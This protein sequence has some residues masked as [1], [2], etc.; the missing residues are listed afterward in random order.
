MGTKP[1]PFPK[2]VDRADLLQV[3]LTLN[4]I[5]PDDAQLTAAPRK[6]GGPVSWDKRIERARPRDSNCFDGLSFVTDRQLKAALEEWLGD[7]VKAPE[8]IGR[9]K[10]LS[11]ALM[12]NLISEE[13]AAAPA[14]TMLDTST[15]RKM[16]SAYIKANNLINGGDNT[17]RKSTAMSR[18]ELL[19]ALLEAGLLSEAQAEAKQVR[20]DRSAALTDRY[21]SAQACR[22]TSVAKLLK[23]LPN[24]SAVQNA[25]IELSN[26]ASLL[27]Y[28]R[29]FL[30]WLHLARL[31]EEGAPLPNM[32]GDQLNRFVRQAYTIRTENSGVKNPELD[33]TFEMHKLLFP[34]LPR[35]NQ[36]N[37]VT[38][39]ANAYAGAMRRHFANAD[40]VKQRIK[41]FASARLFG[42]ASMPPP[43]GEEDADDSE[44]NAVG[45]R[46]DVGSSPLYNVVS[47]LECKGFVEEAMHP[48]Q[49]EVLNEIR[50]ILG[51]PRGTELD[52]NWLRA[53]IH[54]SIR[55]SLATVQVLD[56]LRD[57]ADSLQKELERRFPDKS[58]RPKL[59]KGS[60]RGL[61]FA[62]LNALKRRFVTVDATDMAPLLG[63][64][65]EGPLIAHAVREMLLPNV[66]AIYGEKMA[67]HPDEA[68]ARGEAWYLTGTFDTDGYSI[69]PHFQRRKTP[70]EAVDKSVSPSSKQSLPEKVLSPPRL[71]LLVD[72]GRVN[73]VTITVM[74]DGKVVMRT[75]KRRTRPLKFTLTARQYYSLTGQTRSRLIR[76]R[77]Q[78]KDVQGAGL[79]K[80]QSATSLRTGSCHK[81]VEYIK[82]SMDHAAASDQGAEERRCL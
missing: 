42:L 40:T 15:L 53:N 34:I 31:V 44:A 16:W 36:I 76:E 48:R 37:V 1:T 19:D 21:L 63:L 51:L 60:A 72:P 4:L 22:R 78:R 28:Q 79:R 27:F 32:E 39:A 43:K 14:P 62:P 3:A 5:S 57:Q 59:K 74:L 71:L 30:I 73:I 49:V 58:T 69:H 8:T 24:A 67:H 38:H 10:L 70:K 13:Q 68:T 75:H 41:R 61:H 26:Q 82:A 23:G 65:D 9:Q 64:P 52:S 6:K 18:K 29:S 12:M 25:L 55:F 54:Q 77:R 80:A 66:K 11:Q 46:P 56:D 81:V 35:P 20:A 33:K 47:A 50:H 17:R 7:G 2:D 45:E